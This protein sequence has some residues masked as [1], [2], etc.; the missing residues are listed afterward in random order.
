ML[1]G[2]HL[3]KGAIII[4]GLMCSL[5]CESFK[6]QNKSSCSVDDFTI[7]LFPYHENTEFFK[8]FVINDKNY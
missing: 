8:R 6:T 1:A 5:F 2:V 4:K 3:V 7:Y